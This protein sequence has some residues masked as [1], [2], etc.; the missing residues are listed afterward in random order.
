MVVNLVANIT[1][2]PITAAEDIVLDTGNLVTANTVNTSTKVIG[3]SLIAT[4]P[5]FPGSFAN[6]IP[7]LPKN[8]DMTYVSSVLLPASPNVAEAINQVIECN[9]DCWIT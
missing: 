5:T 4:T 9:C 8:L 6:T 1:N 3:G 2:I 7:A